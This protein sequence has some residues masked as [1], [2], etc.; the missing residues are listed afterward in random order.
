MNV[1]NQ[2]KSSMLLLQSQPNYVKW[3]TPLIWIKRKLGHKSTTKVSPLISLYSLTQV[4]AKV[5][6]AHGTIIFHCT[7]YGLFT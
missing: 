3:T 2:L 4:Q 7:L 5:G 6:V 1:L